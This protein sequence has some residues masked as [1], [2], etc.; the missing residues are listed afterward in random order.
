[1]TQT[2]ETKFPNLIYYVFRE[3]IRSIKRFKD[4]QMRVDFSNIILLYYG[5][6]Y[7]SIALVA[8][9]RVI[10]LRTKIQLYLK[11]V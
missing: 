3:L 7:L 5:R 1:M 10:S 8:I 11:C 2:M 9:F 4:D 6:Q